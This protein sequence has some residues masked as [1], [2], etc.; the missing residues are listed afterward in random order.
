MEIREGGS[1]W[2]TGAERTTKLPLVKLTLKLNLPRVL[3]FVSNLTVS[4][5]NRFSGSEMIKKTTINQATK[6]KYY[7]RR[8]TCHNDNV[9]QSYCQDISVAEITSLLRTSFN[10]VL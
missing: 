7:N 8:L 9:L 1:G 5:E 3:L 4:S 6:T 2:T 10:S